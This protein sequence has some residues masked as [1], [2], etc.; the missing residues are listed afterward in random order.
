MA[1]NTD[2][3]KVRSLTFI[4]RLLKKRWRQL[5]KKTVFEH[6]E[7]GRLLVMDDQEPVIRMMTRIFERL[8]YAVESCLDGKE[9]IRLYREAN[10]RGRPFDL[11][12]LDLTVPAGTHQGDGTGQRCTPFS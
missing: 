6:Q 3:G 4:C 10:D 8:G 12:V 1:F 9:A 7:H 11:V 5:K 2:Q